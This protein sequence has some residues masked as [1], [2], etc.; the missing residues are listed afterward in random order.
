MFILVF[1]QCHADPPDL[2][3]FPTRRSSD[4]RERQPRLLDRLFVR[5]D[6]DGGPPRGL[7]RRVQGGRRVRGSSGRLLV[8]TPANSARSEE[9]T[10]E[11]QSRRDLVCRLLL[12]K[13]K[14]SVGS[15]V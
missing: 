15:T 5:R 14:I 7:S 2:N 9:H 6:D 3:S 1:Y 4:L 13:K 10:S 12:E 8:G 11:L